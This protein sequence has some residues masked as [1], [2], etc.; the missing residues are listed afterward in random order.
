M[1]KMCCCGPKV[2]YKDRI[3]YQD[4]IIYQEKI[5]YKDN[6]KN[7]KENYHDLKDNLSGKTHQFTDDSESSETS[8][9]SDTN[10]NHFEI[11]I[12]CGNKKTKFKVKKK[13][14]VSK[15][16]TKFLELENP[17]QD[18]EGKLMRKGS[19]LKPKNTLEELGISKD[20]TL[21]LV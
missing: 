3:E 11:F 20:E 2:V 12:I 7:E 5:V 4:K 14:S 8:V 21:Y 15:V 6:P 16:I 18:I 17:Q 13:Y 9:W 1:G 19:P 10:P